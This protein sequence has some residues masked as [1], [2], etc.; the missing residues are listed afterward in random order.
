MNMVCYHSGDGSFFDRVPIT[1]L[2]LEGEG[3]K[4]G[5]FIFFF[6]MLYRAGREVS[7]SWR[8]W[9]DF[10]VISSMRNTGGG[11]RDGRGEEAGD[12]GR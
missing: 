12:H 9:K 8:G 10:Q 1:S 7:E 5:E 6:R 11:W 2:L 3:K 4:P